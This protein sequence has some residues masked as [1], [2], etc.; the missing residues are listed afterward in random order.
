MHNL[1][2]SKSCAMRYFL[3]TALISVMFT[4]SMRAQVVF[5]SLPLDGVNGSSFFIVNHVDHDT[6]SGLRDYHCGTKTYDGHQGTDFV[7]RSFKTMDSGVNVKAVASGRVIFVTDTQYDR[8][9]HTNA[10]GFGNYIGINHQN[11]LWTYYAHI[12]KNS[13]L[14]HVGDSVTA[15]QV[16]AKVGCAG[17]CTDPHVHLEVYDY[18]STIVDPF[19]GTCQT[20]TSSAWA[21]QPAYDTSLHLIDAGFTPYLPNLDTLR[22]RYLVKDTFQYGIDTTVDFWVQTQGVHRGDSERFEWFTPSGASWFTYTSASAQTYWYAYNWS[23]ISVPN[24][25]GWWTAKYSVNNVLTATRR[26]YV[27]RTSSVNSIA[28][29][30]DQPTIF[31]NPTTGMVHIEGNGVYPVVVTD[32]AGRELMRFTSG[33]RDIDLSTLPPA[34][35]LLKCGNWV[36]KVMR[37]N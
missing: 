30:N 10:L 17:N 11:T 1:G 19:S 2:K 35:Y 31:P 32:M 37:N 28:P 7:I 20:V 9:K 15:G 12:R 5:T 3:L 25:G 13:A 36:T 26:F 14:V 6:T 34:L 33:T 21:S 24:I 18:Y 27:V 4:C 29:Q 23:Y 8:N 16:I 22:E